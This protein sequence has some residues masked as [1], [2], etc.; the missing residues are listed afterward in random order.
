MKANTDWAKLLQKA[1][2]ARVDEIPKGFRPMDDW[3][4]EFDVG[5]STWRRH[6]P[7]LEKQ[8]E[9]TRGYYR[10]ELP[11]GKTFKRVFWKRGK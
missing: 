11:N 5:E 7:I 10:V 4:K 2:S 9:M 1:N 6:I 8:G 3:L